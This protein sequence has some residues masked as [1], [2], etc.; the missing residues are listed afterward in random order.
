MYPFFLFQIPPNATDE[1]VEAR[2]HAL[3]T[4]YS[5]EAAPEQFA[6][7]RK[8][9][10]ALRTKEKRAAVLVSYHDQ[11]GQA[12]LNEYPFWLQEQA[13]KRLS[14]EQLRERLVEANLPKIS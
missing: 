11:T 10:E 6:Q 8:A 1:E 5:P 2:Y 14:F 4:R 12:L 3:I 13:R 9:Y 7:I